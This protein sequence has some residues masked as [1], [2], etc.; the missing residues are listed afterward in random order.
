VIG[1]PGVL[2]MAVS[3]VDGVTWRDVSHLHLARLVRQVCG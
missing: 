2:P 3:W 1:E